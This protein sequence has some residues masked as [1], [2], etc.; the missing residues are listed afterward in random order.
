[1]A[2]T[3]APEL[4]AAQTAQSRR[5]IIELIAG[6]LAADFPFPGNP[7]ANPDSEAQGLAVPLFLSTGELVIIFAEFE[8]LTDLGALQFVKTDTDISSFSPAVTVDSSTTSYSYV[9]ALEMADGNI[10]VVAVLGT[11]TLVFYRVS[12]AGGKLGEVQISSMTGLLGVSVALT[13]TG[14]VVVYIREVGGV[15]SIY[16]RTSA[17]FIT[18]GAETALTITDLSSATPVQHPQLFRLADDSYFLALS[19]A[20]LVSGDT[21]IFNIGSSTSADFTTWSAISAVTDTTTVSRDYLY[22]DIVQKADGS[23]I[24]SAQENNSYLELTTSSPGWDTTNEINATNMWVD[25]AAGGLYLSSIDGHGCLGMAKIDIATWTIDTFYDSTTTPPIPAIFTAGTNNCNFDRANG[26]KDGLATIREYDKLAVAVV[27]FAADTIRAFYFADQSGTYGEDARV[28]VAHD[29]PDH[30][31]VKMYSSDI[32]GDQLWLTFIHQD[33]D[34]PAFTQ[35]VITGYIDL[36]QDTAPYDFNIVNTTSS[37]TDDFNIVGVRSYIFGSANV[38]LIAAMQTSTTRIPL[39]MISLEEDAVIRYYRDDY[40]TDFPRGGVSCATYI[41]GVIYAVPYRNESIAADTDKWGLLQIDVDGEDRMTYYYPPWLTTPGNH[42]KDMSVNEALSEI[43]LRTEYG[44]AIFNYV[45]KTWTRLENNYREGLPPSSLY[46]S[47]AIAYDSVNEVFFYS[48][49]GSVFYVPRDGLVSY[50]KYITAID[51]SGWI[52]S[53]PSL[54]AAGQNNEHPRLALDNNL[55]Y[56][57]WT[58]ASST[59]TITW[60]KQQAY[61][62]LGSYLTGEVALEMAIDAPFRLTFSLASGYLFDPHNI[63]SLLTAYVGKGRRVSVRIGEKVGGVNYWANQGE[64]VIRSLSVS[65]YVNGKHPITSVVC[66]DV[67]SLWSMHQVTAAGVA[68]QVPEAALSTLITDH[69]SLDESDITVPAMPLSFSFD[70]QWI[71]TYLSDIIDDVA[72]RFQHFSCMDMTG[73]I[74]FRPLSLTEESVN[75][76]TLGDIEEFSPDDNYSDFT[77][78]ITVSG[79]SLTDFEMVYGE[80]P[81]GQ[82]NGTIGWYGFKKDYKIWYSDDHTRRVQNPRLEVIESSVSLLFRLEDSVTECISEEDPYHKYCVVEVKAPNLF[83][84]LGA[85]I[86]MYAAGN[87]LGDAVVTLGGMTIPVGRRLEGAGILLAVMVLGSMGNFQYAVHG[88]PVGYL[89]RSYEESADDTDLQQEIGMVIEQKIDGFACHTPTHCATIADFEMAVTK[90]QR[91]RVGIKK[92]THLQDEI[93]DT[94][95]APHPYTTIAHD[96]FITNITRR[97]KPSSGS[98]DGYVRDEIE[99]WVL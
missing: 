81:V 91:G 32:Y 94:V 48:N 89:K 61:L 39:T 26:I 19:Y 28:N 97:Y 52:F 98:G 30:T 20:S 82:V 47:R 60:D 6:R 66:E 15:Y 29:V 71:D 9:D 13:D 68:A 45:S 3:L 10:G 37:G 67:R 79:Q 99:G 18:W 49:R 34:F 5:P 33:Q 22:P 17:D 84:E 69:S 76:Y 25:E 36:T 2:I 50:S 4:L 74:V 70:A 73:G 95:T 88:Q 31:S 58:D 43:Y 57:T 53:E 63:N 42:L 59:D 65:G 27:D 72:N 16:S 56:S 23:L 75:T 64:Y 85:A 44:V 38:G 92:I 62:D 51:S 86:Y 96:I 55:L 54:L 1:M 11:A 8:I 35:R 7:V 90:A 87:A 46:Y 24:I 83:K 21:T 77:N 14:F 40:F 41:D 93:G 80:E 78:R 12:P